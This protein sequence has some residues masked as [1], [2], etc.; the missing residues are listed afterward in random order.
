MESDDQLNVQSEGEE[1]ASKYK[2][3]C[4]ILPYDSSMK[5]VLLF[6]PFQIGNRPKVTQLANDKSQNSGQSESIAHVLPSRGA[7][8]GSCRSRGRLQGGSGI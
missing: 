2:P 7:Q 3:R 5:L 1:R 8:R 6:L 4:G